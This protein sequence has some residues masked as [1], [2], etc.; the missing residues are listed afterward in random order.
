[1]TPTQSRVLAY[2]LNFQATNKYSP[3]LSDISRECLGTE[4]KSAASKHVKALVKEGYLEKS[5][6]GKLKFWKPLQ[7]TCY[8]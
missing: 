7:L 1:M 3:S 5:P 6:T 2:I 4:T 8:S